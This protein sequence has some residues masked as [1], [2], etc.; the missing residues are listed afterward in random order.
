MYKGAVA[1]YLVIPA[2]QKWM[3]K[4]QFY[5]EM[6]Y[7]T[8]IA[9]FVLIR[10]LILHNLLYNRSFGSFTEGGRNDPIV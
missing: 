1:D 9:S 3:A 8:I 2:V 5:M 7:G 4:L 6:N 10:C